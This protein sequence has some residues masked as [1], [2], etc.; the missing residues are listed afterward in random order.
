MRSHP[1]P[2]LLPALCRG[3][4]CVERLPRRGRRPSIQMDARP[5]PRRND[6]PLIGERAATRGATEGGDEHGGA[7]RRQAAIYS[8]Q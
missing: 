3:T 7:T 1:G 2:R 6:A 4:S 5:R 8:Q